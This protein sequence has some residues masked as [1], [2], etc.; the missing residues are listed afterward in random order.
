MYKRQILGDTLYRYRRQS[1]PIACRS[2]ALTRVLLLA[3]RLPD[4]LSAD[5]LDRMRT[6]AAENLT[7]QLDWYQDGQ[8]RQ[9]DGTQ[10]VQIDYIQHNA[11]AF[12]HW[13]ELEG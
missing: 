1:T 7:L 9:G 5:L 8:F 2:E 4:L 6:H 3:R 12:L 13:A 11:T 10:R